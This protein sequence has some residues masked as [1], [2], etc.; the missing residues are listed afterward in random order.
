MES[1]TG[2]IATNRVDTGVI[3]GVVKERVRQIENR[4]FFPDSQN[5]TNAINLQQLKHPKTPTTVITPVEAIPASSSKG[6]DKPIT[7]KNDI[8]DHSPTLI[9]KNNTN[10]NNK[11]GESQ[12]KMLNSSPPTP[13]STDTPSGIDNNDTKKLSANKRGKF[14][15]D[16]NSKV[17]QFENSSECIDSIDTAND[18]KPD[19][20]ASNLIDTTNSDKPSERKERRG[21]RSNRSFEDEVNNKELT[22]TKERRG[23]R[24]NRYKSPED[25]VNNFKSEEK[26]N[27]RRRD[28]RSKVLKDTTQAEDTTNNQDIQNNEGNRHIK[29]NTQIADIDA[30]LEQEPERSKREKG[31]SKRE[32][33][34]SKRE[35]NNINLQSNRKICHGDEH[36]N[37]DED[38]DNSLINTQ[39]VN[40]FLQNDLNKSTEL[41]VS[42][43]STESKEGSKRR[44]G[45]SS[46]KHD[47]E[48]D[49]DLAKKL[50][51]ERRLKKEL[52]REEKRKQRQKEIQEEKE[53][54]KKERKKIREQQLKDKQDRI[55][56]I[57]ERR[58]KRGKLDL[59]NSNAIEIQTED[60]EKFK[61]KHEIM[62]SEK[63]LQE[64]IEL[65]LLDDII[66]KTENLSINTNIKLSSDSTI[67]KQMDG[68]D[69]I[70]NQKVDLSEGIFNFTKSQPV[71]LLDISEIEF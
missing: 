54:K 34:K 9:N 45:R 26:P 55:L 70:D 49:D 63:E 24:S 7:I 41:T 22:E 18:T 30:T 47:V 35:R 36:S 38:N 46:R 40:H 66:N 6:T 39:V 51:E 32:R 59:S 50:K 13:E 65:S 5:K 67:N 8:R 62:K 15:R 4:D 19:E 28:E 48:I 58:A 44:R 25:E 57:K 10:S 29:D 64:E 3:Y 43:K 56:E 31:E 69:K 33:N 52:K 1:T 53:E 68:D 71:N 20:I 12:I 17:K 2:L 21:R 16:R 61:Y 42:I 23:R 27:R 11:E 14:R 60:K 37:E